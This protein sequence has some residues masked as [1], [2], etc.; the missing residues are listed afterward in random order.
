MG[1]SDARGRGAP[2]SGGA[3]SSVSP[4]RRR[5]RADAAESSTH[6]GVDS[7][8]GAAFRRPICGEEVEGATAELTHFFLSVDILRDFVFLNDF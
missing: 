4:E 1:A 7:G 8:D 2:A 6:G 5:R 3:A